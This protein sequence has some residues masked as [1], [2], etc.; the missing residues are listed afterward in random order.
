MIP[1]LW[2]ACAEQ[3]PTVTA[4]VT[5]PVGEEAAAPSMYELEVPLTASDGAATTLDVHRGH[6]VLVSMFYASC[7]SACPMLV[8]KV[9]A[10]EET[11][12][13]PTRADLRVLLVSL[14]PARDDPAALQEA[15]QRYGADPARWVLAV[16][17]EDRVRELAAVMGIQYRPG[18]DGEIH[19]T[20][21]LV[22]L[23]ADGHPIARSEGADGSTE[24][25]RSALVELGS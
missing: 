17:P 8:Q 4:P 12:D 9:R 13:D 11:L 10:F 15:A 19:H 25:L 5:P 24:S 7:H 21:T 3:P 20:S 22:L 14:D 18:A 2:L 23:D 16:P 1:L 6:P